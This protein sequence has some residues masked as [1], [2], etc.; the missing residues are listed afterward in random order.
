MLAGLIH[1]FTI[2]C[3]FLE[4]QAVLLGLP[5]TMIFTL[6][7]LIWGRKKLSQRPLLAFFSIMC[8]VAVS[9]FLGWGLY[10]GGFPEFSAVGLI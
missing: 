6:L 5:F 1:G 10:W 8:L 7:V 9:L 3:V 2:F 4:G